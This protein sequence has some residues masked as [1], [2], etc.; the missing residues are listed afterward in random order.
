MSADASIASTR[1]RGTSASNASVTRPVPQPTSSTVASGAMPSSRARTSEAHACCGA[2][3]SVIRARVPGSAHRS[4]RLVDCECCRYSRKGRRKMASIGCARAAGGAQARGRNRLPGGG[5]IA[6][7]GPFAGA[8]RARVATELIHVASPA[9]R[10]RFGRAQSAGAG[11]LRL[12]RLAAR[13]AGDLRT[14]C[15]GSR[16]L[17]PRDRARPGRAGRPRH[18]R[19]D[20]PA[21]GMRSPGRRRRPGDHQHGILSRL[22]WHE[23]AK[24]MRTPIQGEALVDSLSRDALATLLEEASSGIDERA[25]DEYWK[26]SPPRRPPRDARALSLVRARRAQALPGQARCTRG[27]HADPVGPAGRVHPAHFA[28]RFARE[29][30]GSSSCCSKPAISCSRTSRSAAPRR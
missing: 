22:G 26:S 28:S 25:V 11:S 19:F 9:S 29:I 13:S 27:A 6:R 2:L 15:R 1:P 18:R 12:R 23:I 21:L 14:P 3:D 5:G 24:T 16:T 10:A 20:R 30:P 7:V 4:V 8:V 17:P